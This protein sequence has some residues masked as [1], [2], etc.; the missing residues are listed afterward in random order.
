MPFLNY[1]HWNPYFGFYNLIFQGDFLLW[2]Q[3]NKSL[4]KK[5]WI[6]ERKRNKAN[7]PFIS[8]LNG[9]SSCGVSAPPDRLLS[10]GGESD[11]RQGETPCI[12][13]TT[14]NSFTILRVKWSFDPF[15][16]I[17]EEKNKK[18]RKL[19]ISGPECPLKTR[20]TLWQLVLP[21][22][23]NCKVRI[24]SLF[25]L[26]MSSSSQHVLLVFD[27]HWDPGVPHCWVGQQNLHTFQSAARASPGKMHRHP[28]CHGL[29]RE[30]Q[31]QSSPELPG[32]WRMPLTWPPEWALPLTH[33][34]VNAAPAQHHPAEGISALEL[35]V[36][37]MKALGVLGFPTI[38]V[39]S[40]A[41]THSLMIDQRSVLCKKLSMSKVSTVLF[42]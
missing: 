40:T 1:W 34:D 32:G 26:A 15:S 41:L 23:S 20:L 9:T 24:I 39:G 19:I 14:D 36:I 42:K 37:L 30:L 18:R 4:R 13:N 10:A 11:Q 12:H 5:P 22:I 16:H 7:T 29:T 35:P 38:T 33:Q 28:H 3:P 27:C 6:T 21:S 31:S 8:T 2:V 17:W 25:L